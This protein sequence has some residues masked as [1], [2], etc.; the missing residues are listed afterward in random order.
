MTRAIARLRCML[1]P[2]LGFALVCAL[3]PVLADDSAT[4]DGYGRIEGRDCALAV[5]V[6]LDDG[7][8][9]EADPPLA[10]HATVDI[11][12]V[13]LAPSLCGQTPRLAGGIA[14]VPARPAIELT[15]AARDWPRHAG[16]VDAL[17]RRFPQARLR[18]RVLG[19]ASADTDAAAV[20]IA[21]MLLQQ[22]PEVMART[23]I[24][25]LDPAVARDAVS[26]WRVAFDAFESARSVHADSAADVA[27]L[28][29]AAR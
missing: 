6:V 20:Q 16:D 15:L 26:G 18:L 24:T 1:P 2:T 29:A 25:A 3:P 11:R 5:R 7:R 21:T 10:Q 28:L 17:T 13:T 4:V 9:F 27:R 23:S 14:V 8:R 12:G 19:P 22:R